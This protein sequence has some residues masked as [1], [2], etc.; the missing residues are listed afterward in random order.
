[1]PM[2][3]RFGR[4]LKILGA[5][6]AE[7]RA[8]IS[9]YRS[10]LASDVKARRRSSRPKRRQF[11]SGFRG[12]NA[13]IGFDIAVIGFA[14]TALFIPLCHDSVRSI[15]ASKISLASRRQ[16][17]VDSAWAQQQ[18]GRLA[19]GEVAAAGLS[20]FFCLRTDDCRLRIE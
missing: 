4:R 7:G 8:R 17:A 1:M 12:E 20:I 10:L 3:R 5:S 15:A 11:C 13:Y 9:P 2:P 19:A 18:R 6:T 16:P 14:A